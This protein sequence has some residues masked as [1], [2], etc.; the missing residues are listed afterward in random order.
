MDIEREWYVVRND[1]QYPNHAETPMPGEIE[2][3]ITVNGVPFP[4]LANVPENGVWLGFGA[5]E[6]I[7]ESMARELAD[8]IRR[9]GGDVGR[10]EAEALGLAEWSMSC[11]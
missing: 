9:L 3:H 6:R 1:R 4:V 2:T 11:C 8:E 10:A 5:W 7:S